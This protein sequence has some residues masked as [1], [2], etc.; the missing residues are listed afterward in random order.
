MENAQSTFMSS[1]FW[2]ER[3][4]PTA[5]LKTLEVMER[6]KSWELITQ[7]GKDVTARWLGL[8]KD[9]ACRFR[10]PVF[11]QSLASALRVPTHLLTR[12]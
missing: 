12:R 5:A 11:R 4:G 6:V 10:P 8:G 1:T 3:I 7:T 9:T 2:T